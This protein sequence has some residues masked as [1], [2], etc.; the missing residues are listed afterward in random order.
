MPLN[1][2]M[3][4]LR[5]E[6]PAQMI[7]IIFRCG[8]VVIRIRTTKAARGAEIEIMHPKEEPSIE[9]V[10]GANDNLAKTIIRTGDAK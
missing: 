8:A 2:H 4:P 10:G 1:T 5:V 6:V 7:Y 9:I 3:Y